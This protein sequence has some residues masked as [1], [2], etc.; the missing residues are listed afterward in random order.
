VHLFRRLR[1]PL[2]QATRD[3]E[4]ELDLLPHVPLRRA[5]AK[6]IARGYRQRWT[7]E[8]AFQQLAA[9]CPAEMNTLGEP[10]AAL[11]GFCVALV[12]S[13]MGA[14][15][16]AAVRRVHGDTLA[17]ALSLYEGATESAHT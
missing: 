12:A 5:S 3:G 10:Q 6:R 9:Y 1:G 4:R 2:D 17:Q 7:L 8:T 13:T 16:L 15:V 11:G 14:V